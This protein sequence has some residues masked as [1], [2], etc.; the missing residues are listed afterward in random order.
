M[1]ALSLHI[2]STDSTITVYYNSQNTLV[3]SVTLAGIAQVSVPDSIPK[4][5]GSRLVKLHTQQH[6][7]PRGFGSD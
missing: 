1:S 3:I 2:E 6:A 5:E 7:P 4:G